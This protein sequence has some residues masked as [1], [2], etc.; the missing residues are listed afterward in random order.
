MKVQSPCLLRDRRLTAKPRITRTAT[1][2]S[3]NVERMVPS[4]HPSIRGTAQT[5]TV[6]TLQ[7]AITIAHQWVG[8]KPHETP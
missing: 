7:E 4:S 3:F 8:P 2:R 5:K 6:N 1:G